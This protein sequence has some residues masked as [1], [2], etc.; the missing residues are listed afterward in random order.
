MA[1]DLLKSP[2][3]TELTVL[4]SCSG[5]LQE[6]G[7]GPGQ[8]ASAHTVSMVT[9]SVLVG[10]GSIFGSFNLINKQMT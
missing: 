1:Q 10:F 3:G 8:E 5:G 7:P 2:G 9:A 4:L 6:P